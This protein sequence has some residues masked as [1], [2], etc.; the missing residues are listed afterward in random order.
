MPALKCYIYVQC[1]KYKQEFE[2]LKAVFLVKTSRNLMTF[3][4][5][6]P[7]HK[8]LLTAA[9]VE[10]LLTKRSRDSYYRSPCCTTQLF[11]PVCLRV[12][13]NSHLSLYPLTYRQRKHTVGRCH[14]HA[15]DLVRPAHKV[16]PMKE[17]AA[18]LT[19]TGTYIHHKRVDH[20]ARKWIVTLSRGRQ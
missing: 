5:D 11:L 14:Y 19:R 2:C 1:V 15:I 7:R 12:C 3:E 9:C 16:C 20:R 17:C 8:F 13:S 4:T 10:R 6:V 18:V